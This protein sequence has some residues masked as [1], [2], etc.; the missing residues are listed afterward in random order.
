M[1]EV[2]PVIL[3]PVSVTLSLFVLLMNILTSSDVSNDIYSLS[4]PEPL[5]IFVKD[6]FKIDVITV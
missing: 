5:P 1:N 3:T 4:V 2:T 6:V